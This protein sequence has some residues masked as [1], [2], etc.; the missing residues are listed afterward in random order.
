MKNIL[1]FI[2]VQLHLF[3]L[4]SS[5]SWYHHSISTNT[6]SYQ[7]HP[8]SKRHGLGVHSYADDTQLYFHTAP[9]MVDNKVQRLVVCVED[10]HQWM[11]ANRLRLNEDQTQFIWLGTPHQLSEVQWY[12]SGA[13]TSRFRQKLRFWVSYSTASWLLRHTSDGS[14]A[15]VFTIC[16]SW[17]LFTAH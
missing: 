12:H 14:L 6:T 2:D 3:S 4:S 7:H 11:N 1:Q 9:A 17:R 16:D 8:H 5:W 13:L 15:S 10:I